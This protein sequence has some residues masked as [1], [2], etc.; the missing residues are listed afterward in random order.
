[1]VVEVAEK[2]RLTR[3]QVEGGKPASKIAESGM[4]PQAP[5]SHQAFLGPYPDEG[6]V[7]RNPSFRAGQRNTAR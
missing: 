1:M 3:R 2:G 4:A 5:R 7:R 6:D